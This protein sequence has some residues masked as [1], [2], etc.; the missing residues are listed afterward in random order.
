MAAVI[1]TAI[2]AQLSLSVG[3]AIENGNDV[4]TVIANFFSFFTILSN[5]T[6]AVIL[7]WAALWYFTRGTRARAEP[8]GLAIALASITTYMIVTGLVYNI[9]LRNIELPQGSEP[10]PWSNETLHVVAPVF[11]L[12]DLFLGPLRRRLNWSAVVAIAVFP[13]V[14]AVYTLV[15]GPLVTSPITGNPYWYPYPFMDP[16][17]FANGY[18]GVSVYVV[19]HRDRDHR[20]RTPGGVDRTTPRNFVC[21]LHTTFLSPVWATSLFAVPTFPSSALADHYHLISWGCHTPG[22]IVKGHLMHWS[23]FRIAAAVTALSG[24]VAGFIVNIDRA[25]RGAA[26]SRAGAGQLLQPVHDR[27]VAAQR[28]GAG[29]GR[30]WS[31]AAPGNIARALGDRPGHRGRCR[32]GAAPRHRV[33]RAAARCPVRHRPRRH[34]RGSDCW[35]PTRSRCCTSCCRSTSSSI[36]CWAPR[37]R[38]LPWWSLAVFVGYPL[39]WT[40]YTMVRG[41]SGS[42]TPTAARRG[43]TRTRSSIRTAQAY[44]SAF[45]YIG[46]MMVAF[47]AIGAI[48]IAIGRYREKRAA[49]RAGAAPGH[50]RAA[51]LTSRGDAGSGTSRPGIAVRAEGARSPRS[52]GLED[53]EGSPVPARR[54]A[55]R[56]RFLRGPRHLRRRRLDAR[57]GRHPLHLH[58]RPRPARRGR[59]RRDPRPRARVRRRD[60]AAGRLQD[61]ARRGGLRRPR[62]RRLPHPLG[63]HAPTSTRRRSAAR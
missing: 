12:L 8:R 33:Q 2:V 51:R 47:L 15:R 18:L 56:H 55:R 24:I 49:V 39:G 60:L 20:G 19:A 59:H 41:G 62:V 53:V 54:R 50:R 57:Q 10:I 25:S 40:V 1:A 23:W 7:V 11:L 46:A 5:A 9:L 13:I 43:G 45:A 38:G 22:G 42:R 27:F 32:P 21:R 28:R 34:C 14:W 4:P 16:N 29:G 26:G 30:D 61:R 63:R 37:R 48:I 31:H 36:C 6:S 44:G 17:N 3:R 35:T 52:V 58:R